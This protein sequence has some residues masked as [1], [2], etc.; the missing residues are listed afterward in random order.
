MILSK[1]GF[2]G[3]VKKAVKGKVK[4]LKIVLKYENG[5]GVIDGV[6][7]VSKPGQR[8]Y[9]KADEIKKVRGGLGVSIISTPKG[10]MVG[11]EARKAKLGG[12]VLLEIW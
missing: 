11:G 12:E 9:A 10:L 2:L 3:E 8:I 1:S 4:S 5:A 7:R 6:K